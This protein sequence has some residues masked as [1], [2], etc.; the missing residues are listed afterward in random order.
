MKTSGEIF[1]VANTGSVMNYSSMEAWHC[2]ND[3]L[4]RTSCPSNAFVGQRVGR[5]HLGVDGR[6][7]VCLCPLRKEH[8]GPGL[9]G[10][11]SA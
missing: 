11:L 1:L 2:P 4:P 8:P 6:E 7:H 3:T 5:D 9:P 10:I